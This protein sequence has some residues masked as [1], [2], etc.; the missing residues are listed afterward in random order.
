MPGM[1]D[2]VLNVGMTDDVA[3]ALGRATGDDRFAWDTARRFIQSYASIVL[4]VPPAVL[5]RVSADALGPDD[6]RSL[7]AAELAT[8]TRVMRDALAAAGHEIPTD[9][10]R[11]ITAAV[12]AVFSS[13]WSDRALAYRRVEQIDD[14]LGTAVTIQKMTFGNRGERSGTGVAFT[15]DPSTGER[16][17]VGDFMVGA[18][19]EDVVAGTHATLPLSELRSQWPEIADRLDDAAAAL[20]RELVDMADIEFTVEEGEFWLLQVRRGKRSATAA[21]RIALD[22][23]EDPDFPVTRAEALASVADILDDPPTRTNPGHAGDPADSELARGLAASPGRVTGRLCVDI[24]DAIAAGAHGESII[25]VRNETSPADIAG[26]AE[27]A[28]IVTALGGLVSH[29]AV[30]ARSWGIPAI[31]GVSDIV[32]RPDGVEISGTHYAVGTVLTVDGGS[33]TLLHGDHP[34]D[35]VEVEEVAILRRWQTELARALPADS[36]PPRHDSGSTTGLALST[37][38]YERV[39]ALKGATTADALA[40]V[41]GCSL[42]EVQPIVDDL[43]A[44]GSAQELPGGRVRLLPPALE[45]VDA[46]FRA[47]AARLA[48]VVESQWD[49]FHELNLHFKHVVAAWQVRTVDGTEQPNDHADATYDGAVVERLRTEI[50]AGIVPIIDAVAVAEARF[51]RYAER[52]EAAIGSVE[53]GQREMFAHPLADSYHT[54]WFELHEELIRLSGRTRADEAAAGRA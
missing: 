10:L 9:P 27:A 13:W 39:I 8:A 33:G 20:E 35:E 32:V 49:D 53:A 47:D 37:Q 5:A 3:A 41:L 1:M 25:L 17:V 4:S 43:V 31:V 50:H 42:D 54:V 45:R 22:L 30:V 48:P 36:H 51:A 16:T 18:Q 26:I 19:G 34:A 21:L 28:G 7:D 40:A 2:T 6:G 24:D 44:D 52:L 23:A 14:A 46:R 15:R 11:Q 38:D 29:A 12:A